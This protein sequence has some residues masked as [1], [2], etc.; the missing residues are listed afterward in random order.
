LHLEIVEPTL[1]SEAGHCAALFASLRGAAPALP[2]R[3]WVDR[4]AHLPRFERQGVILQRFFSRRWRKPQAFWLYRRLLR[5][6]APMLVPTATWFDLRALDLAAGR[7]IAPQRASLYF[8]KWRVSPQRAQALHRLAQRQP[9][10]ALFGTSQAIVAA[11]R[12]AGFA[13]VEQV[14]PVL[15]ADVAPHMAASFRALLSAGAARADKGFAQVVDLVEHMAEVGSA[16]P[17]V[18]QASG[19]HYGRYDE[20]TRADLARLRSCRYPHLAVLTDTLDARQYQDLFAGAVCLQPYRRAEYADKMSAVTFDA[21]RNGAPIVTVAGTTMAV[22]ARESGA[23]L[24]IDEPTP[25]ALLQACHTVVQQYPQYS[26]HARRAGEQHS[27]AS[28][29]KPMVEELERAFAQFGP[30]HEPQR[31][32]SHA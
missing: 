8:H 4:H 16:L 1:V 10:L 13:R 11:L 15:G 12:E 20:R 22:I 29:W 31:V 25:Q 26:E 21:L 7:P 23:G 18:V 17:I 9:N 32:E 3:L 28:A 14:E 2:Y 5:S 6:G 27:A 30:D 19:D 24:V